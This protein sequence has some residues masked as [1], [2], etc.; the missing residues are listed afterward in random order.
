MQQLAPFPI[1]M[2][3]LLA[4]PGFLAPVAVVF[5]GLVEG[6]VVAPV[7]DLVPFINF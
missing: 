3:F 4:V 2:K 6:L 1:S 7:F 5:V